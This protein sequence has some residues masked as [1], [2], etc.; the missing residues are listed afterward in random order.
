VCNTVDVADRD[1]GR[2][3][4]SVCANDAYDISGPNGERGRPTLKLVL[5]VCCTQPD[6]IMF[7]R[8]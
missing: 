8:R 5:H 7:R 6:L 4:A 2:P 1:E 3:G